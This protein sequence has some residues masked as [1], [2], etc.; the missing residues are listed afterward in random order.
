MSRPDD[1]GVAPAS[2]RRRRWPLA[3]VAALVALGSALVFAVLWLNAGN[4]QPVLAIA[5]PVP[6]GQVLSGDDLRVVRV[7]SDPGIEPIPASRRREVI[8]QTSTSGLVPGSLLTKGQLG[9]S[10]TLLGPGQAVVGVALKGGQLPTPNL[11]VG[12]QVLIVQ[13]PPPGAASVTSDASGGASTQGSGFVLGS[14]RVFGIEKAEDGSGDVVASLSVAR[15]I[16][17]AVVGAGSAERVS[18]VLVQSQ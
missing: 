1:A 8:G 6:A 4:R 15:E 5:R 10:V 2:M 14:G 13:T 3:L 17:A 11:K 12:D 18:L 7:S 9:G 16:A